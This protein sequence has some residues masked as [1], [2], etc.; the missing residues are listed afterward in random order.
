M[1]KY[2]TALAKYIYQQVC[3]VNLP[4]TGG[5]DFKF[6]IHEIGKLHP[7]CAEIL[8]NLNTTEDR[9]KFFKTDMEMKIKFPDLWQLQ[10]NQ[11]EQKL[12]SFSRNLIKYGNDNHLKIEK[13]YNEIV[14][15]HHT[16]PNPDQE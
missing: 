16:F 14:N 12:K 7:E 8:V 5:D 1:K 13:Y 15:E 11:E 3:N 4:K 6:Y 9:I 10:L 2:G